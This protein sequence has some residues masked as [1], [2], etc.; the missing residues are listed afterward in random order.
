MWVSA[1][2]LFC[3]N[4]CKRPNSRRISK[5]VADSKVPSPSDVLPRIPFGEEVRLRLEAGKIVDIG[6]VR[7]QKDTAG[8]DSLHFHVELR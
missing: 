1:I 8:V 3:P 4:F 5:L 7:G 2:I 6:I